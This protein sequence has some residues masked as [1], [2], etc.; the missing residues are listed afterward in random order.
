MALEQGPFVPLHHQMHHQPNSPKCCL[1]MFLHS[2]AHVL[3]WMWREGSQASKQAAI[4]P[5][6]LLTA[7]MASMLHG[8]YCLFLKW[9]GVRDAKNPAPLFLFTANRSSAKDS[10][11]A[12]HYVHHKERIQT[13][14]LLSTLPYYSMNNK[15]VGRNN[16]EPWQLFY[17]LLLALAAPAGKCAML[18]MY[19]YIMVILFQCLPS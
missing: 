15:E 6:I 4:P 13:P 2:C 12:A 8:P 16:L 5:S 10:K 14:R 3:Q 1:C 18:A 17:F 7:R 9:R 11:D 19:C